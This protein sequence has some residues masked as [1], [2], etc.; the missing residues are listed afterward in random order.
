ME[1]VFCFGCGNTIE[2]STER[3][4]L[5]GES[6]SSKRVLAAWKS[7]CMKVSNKSEEELDRIA[8]GKLPSFARK[9]L[10][11][12]EADKAFSPPQS[13]KK[14][15]RTTSSQQSPPVMV[16]QDFLAI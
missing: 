1:S 6:D 9:R 15:R 16:N 5:L 14:Y 10:A 7:I 12:E 2:K 8:N 3:R 13:V 4:R 11:S